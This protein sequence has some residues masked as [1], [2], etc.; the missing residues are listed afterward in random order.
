MVSVWVDV[1]GYGVVGGV[2]VV[3]GVWEDGDDGLG[4]DEEP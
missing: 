2:G 3:V 4:Q 1:V